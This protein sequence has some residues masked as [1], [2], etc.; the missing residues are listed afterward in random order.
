MKT[1]KT[2]DKIIETQRKLIITFFISTII[3]IFFMSGMIFN[4]IVIKHNGNKMPVFSLNKYSTFTHFTF[5][6][7]SEINYY[8]LSDLFKFKK[9]IYSIGDIIM[10]IN[11]ILLSIVGVFEIKY[12]IKLNKLNKKLNRDET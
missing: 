1:T 3:I 5:Q 4:Q 7:K 8:Y 2:K 11:L 6:N 12:I 9:T 10:I